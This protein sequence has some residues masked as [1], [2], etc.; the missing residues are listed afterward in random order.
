MT[1]AQIVEWVEEHFDVSSYDNVQDLYRDVRATFAK[2][3]SYFPNEA[4][5]HI[6]S[7]WKNVAS[8]RRTGIY[9]SATLDE[10]VVPKPEI[11]VIDIQELA[12]FEPIGPASEKTFMMPEF[13][14]EVK[15]PGGVFGA[16]KSFGSR[17]GKLFGFGRNR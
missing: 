5:E 8:T 4:E 13:F 3:K 10:Y 9:E 17:I 2:N 16:F 1:Y 12:S 15:K 14:K 11:E 7:H 6:E